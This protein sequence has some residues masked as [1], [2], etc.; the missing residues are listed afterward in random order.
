M[1]E[2]SKIIFHLFI[3][4]TADSIR[5]QLQDISLGVDDEIINLPFELCEDA[6]QETQFSLLAKPVNFRKQNL[7]AMLNALP[8][9]WGVGDEVTGRILENRKVQFLFQS[10]ESMLSVHRRGP[11]TFNELLCFIQKYMPLQTDEELKYIPLWVQIKV[12]P[13]HFLT[14]KMVKYIGEKLGNYIEIDFVGDGA[15]LVDYVRVNIIWNVD[16]PVRFK[17]LFQF[18]DETSVLKSPYEKVRNNEWW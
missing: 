8:R 2:H 16:Y 6:I 4:I 15:I 10:E 3:L 9:L 14:L 7:H 17:R 12:I 13:L 11:W 5:K 1:S 18:E